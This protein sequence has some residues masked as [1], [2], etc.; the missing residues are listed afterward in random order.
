MDSGERERLQEEHDFMARLEGN[1]DAL[2]WRCG[3]FDRTVGRAHRIFA[4]A[5]TEE[6]AERYM[7]LRAERNGGVIPHQLLHEVAWWHKVD[8][9]TEEK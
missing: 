9:T 3:I 2:P 5:D 1:G 8:L 4:S 6:E 7:R